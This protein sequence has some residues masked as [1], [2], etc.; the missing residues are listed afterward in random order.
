MIT[1]TVTLEYYVS[2]V[3]PDGTIVKERRVC[4]ISATGETEDQFRSAIKVLKE[5]FA[6]LIPS[7][8]AA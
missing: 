2:E 7:V 8:T 4:P 5:E 1:A 6:A 3:Q